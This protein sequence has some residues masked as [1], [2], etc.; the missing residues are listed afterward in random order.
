[1]SEEGGGPIVAPCQEGTTLEALDSGL[2]LG[3]LH[4]DAY[5]LEL[6]RWGESKREEWDRLAS[7]KLISPT[8]PPFTI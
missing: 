6:K 3:T 4:F 1:M 7:A 2:C 5:A 8:L